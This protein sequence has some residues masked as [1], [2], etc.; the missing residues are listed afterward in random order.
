MKQRACNF[1]GH[2][3]SFL[4]TTTLLAVSVYRV[5]AAPKVAVSENVKGLAIYTPRPDYPLG[6]RF[7]GEQGAGW[8]VLCVQIKSGRVKKVE[9]A[10]STGH[11]D[12]DAS[13]VRTLKQW[14]F[15]PDALPPI[16]KIIT[17][18]DLVAT[19]DTLVKVPVIFEL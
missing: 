13:T 7:R 16:K 1:L 14:R 12:L 9:V 17:Y 11:S 8:F 15:K 4:I 5:E 3:A 19:G 2:T 18:H 10:R 6:A